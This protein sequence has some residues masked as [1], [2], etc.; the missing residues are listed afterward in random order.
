MDSCFV[1]FGNWF[2]GETVSRKEVALA[3]RSV[4]F[5]LALVTV[6]GKKKEVATSLR[7]LLL[8]SILLLEK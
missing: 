7:E 5:P 4:C 3:L 1:K 6:R 8:T 2:G